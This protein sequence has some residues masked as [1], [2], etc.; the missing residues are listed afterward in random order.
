MSESATGK[1]EKRR[2]QVSARIQRL[3]STRRQGMFGVAEII[4]LGVSA[5]ILLV[6]VVSYVY[7]LVPARSRLHALEL[8]RARLQSQLRSS[9]ELMRQGHDTQSTVDKITESLAGFEETRLPNHSQG[10]MGL[11]GELNQLIRKN[12]VRNT[13]GPAYVPL[14]SST[15]K[16]ST[17]GARSASAKWQSVYPGIAVS[18][19]VEGPYQNLRHF[20]R[21]LEASKQFIIINAIELERA[22]ETNNVS[23]A[24][25]D[26]AG[27]ARASLVSLRLDMATYF[28][29][30]TDTPPVDAV[31]H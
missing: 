4:G 16:S 2:A 10:R 26:A 1:P 15:V 9:Q 3:R 22:T 27:G 12:G 8:E 23:S 14:V 19:T 5:L 20:I 21:D 29:L 6:V 17:V 31:G 7:F 18:V 11:Y 13:A 28:K 30:G 25:G 24:E